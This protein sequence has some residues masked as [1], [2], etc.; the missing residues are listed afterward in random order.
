MRETANS[1][2]SKGGGCL[3]GVVKQVAKI[4]ED[5]FVLVA[6]WKLDAAELP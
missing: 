6:H 2:A 5:W 4:G 3:E 1:S